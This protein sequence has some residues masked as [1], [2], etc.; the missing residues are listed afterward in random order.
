LTPSV[1]AFDASIGSLIA[2]LLDPYLTYLC[3]P[4]PHPLT[5]RGLSTP[6]SVRRFEVCSCKPTS[7]DLPS[8]LVQ[9]RGATVLTYFLMV[10][11]GIIL[12]AYD[13]RF[14]LINNVYHLD[15]LLIIEINILGI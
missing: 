4:F 5:T 7:R 15:R 8:S 6:S 1:Y 13:T 3:T 12:T 11:K 10:S 9:P 2:H 14:R